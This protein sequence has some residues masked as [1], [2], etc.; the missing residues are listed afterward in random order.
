MPVLPAA[1]YTMIHL[2]AV[3]IFPLSPIAIISV[4][5]DAFFEF[6]DVRTDDVYPAPTTNNAIWRGL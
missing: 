6:A 3:R 2:V 1:L 4:E 5:F